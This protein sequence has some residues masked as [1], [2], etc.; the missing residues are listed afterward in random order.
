MIGD[1]DLDDLD[2]Q[3][4]AWLAALTNAAEKTPREAEVLQR[5]EAALKAATAAV[6]AYS[7]VVDSSH[8]R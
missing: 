5:V 7:T 8:R 2:L 3:G 4:K 6:R 1:L